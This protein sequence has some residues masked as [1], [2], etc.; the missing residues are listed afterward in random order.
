MSWRGVVWHVQYSA[1]GISYSSYKATFTHEIWSEQGTFG[2]FL[3]APRCPATTW[4]TP[5]TSSFS[6]RTGG[7]SHYRCLGTFK[8]VAGGLS[9]PSEL[10]CG[11]VGLW[12]KVWVEMLADPNSTNFQQIWPLRPSF[13]T[14]KLG[15]TYYDISAGNSVVVSLLLVLFRSLEWVPNEP[16]GGLGQGPVTLLI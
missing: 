5:R 8:G 6:G 9:Q 3:T 2:P 11:R 14:T 16:C 15:T 1:R 12:C 10:S 7:G 13:L 4:Y